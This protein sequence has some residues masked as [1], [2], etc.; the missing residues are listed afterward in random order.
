MSF[1]FE[2]LLLLFN[3]ACLAV[4]QLIPILQSLVESNR[5]SKPRSTTLEAST[6]NITPPM[7]S[8]I[9]KDKE[10]SE[11]V[12]KISLLLDDSVNDNNTVPWLNEK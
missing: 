4:V 10:Q 6:L 8:C 7:Q 3:A 5:G 1:Q 2:S 9:F 12:G 11:T